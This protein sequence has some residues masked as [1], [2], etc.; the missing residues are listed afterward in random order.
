MLGHG[1][2]EKGY[3]SLYYNDPMFELHHIKGQESIRFSVERFYHELALSFHVC[4]TN[5][6]YQERSIFSYLTKYPDQMEVV[7]ST[8]TGYGI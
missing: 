8:F 4:I 7:S 6:F 3:Y 1:F 2:F 5:L